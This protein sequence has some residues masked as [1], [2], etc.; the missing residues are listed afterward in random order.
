MLKSFFPIFFLWLVIKLVFTGEYWHTTNLAFGALI[1]LP[2]VFA[3]IG[4]W[5]P[6]LYVFHF[7]KNGCRKENLQ[8]YCGGKG[9]ST[10]AGIIIS[11]SP[12][13]MLIGVT[14]FFSIALL[15]HYVSLSSL[16]TSLTMALLVWVKPLDLIYLKVWDDSSLIFQHEWY[17]IGLVFLFL[18]SCVVIIWYAHR[19]N[20][21]RLF[22][23]TESKAFVKKQKQA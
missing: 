5:I 10:F 6:F 7:F 8:S 23:G 4:H 18:L 19:K 9:V 15:T 3:V 17:F 12:W 2:G 20:I 11:F 22:K 13:I 14:L 16:I 21:V 1:F